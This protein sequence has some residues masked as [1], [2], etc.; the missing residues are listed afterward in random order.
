MENTSLLKQAILFE[1]NKSLY[2]QEER[3]IIRAEIL[4]LCADKIKKLTNPIM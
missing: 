2:T 1:Q 4:R 3:E